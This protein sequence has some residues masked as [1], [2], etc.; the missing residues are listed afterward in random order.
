MSFES[1]SSSLLRYPKFAFSL[2]SS[3]MDL[4]TSFFE[5]MQPKVD[6]AF[7]DMAS[8][9]AGA[10]ANPDEGRMVGHYWLRNPDLAP[11]NELRRQITEPL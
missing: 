6:K 8:L 11:N 7:A 3:L 5:T 10:I 9:E 1:Y 4:D 2:D